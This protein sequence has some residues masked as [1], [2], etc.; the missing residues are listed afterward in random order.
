M[1]KVVEITKVADAGMMV[2]VGGSQLDIVAAISALHTSI[3]QKFGKE[4]GKDMIK[5]AHKAAKE[6]YKMMRE[7]KQEAENV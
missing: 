1:K 4:E 3:L 7:A 5:D 2:E 6:M